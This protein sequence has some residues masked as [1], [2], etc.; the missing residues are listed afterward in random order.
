MQE[1]YERVRKCAKVKG[2]AELKIALRVKTFSHDFPKLPHS[3][4]NCFG[5]T[6]I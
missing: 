3:K 2:G 6:Q 1:S 5:Y 4:T